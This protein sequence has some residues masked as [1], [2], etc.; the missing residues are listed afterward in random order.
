MSHLY[1]SLPRIDWSSPVFF[2]IVSGLNFL[3]LHKKWKAMVGVCN[4]KSETDQIMNVAHSTHDYTAVHVLQHSS[5]ILHSCV[6]F[7]FSNLCCM[8]CWW[9]VPSGKHCMYAG[10][11]CTSLMTS[12]QRTFLSPVLRGWAG[13]GVHADT[14]RSTAS[15]RVPP[16]YGLIIYILQLE[17]ST[18]GW[19]YGRDIKWS[20]D[21]FQTQ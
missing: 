3:P 14:G 10:Q 5:N 21:H 16:F 8:V 15:P 1:Q 19:G 7:T 4:L 11:A 2:A 12:H 6:A 17:L 18:W 13:S 20:C 9:T